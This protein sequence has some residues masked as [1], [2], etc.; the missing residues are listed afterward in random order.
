MKDREIEIRLKVEDNKPLLKFLGEKGDFK[1]EKHQKDEYFI[2]AH[3]NFIEAKP[4]KEWLRLRR[5]EDKH[6][7]NYKNWHYDDDGKS[8][9]CD[10]Y[11]VKIDNA[12]KL[13]DILKALN[14]KS[15]VVVD[16]KRKVFEFENYEIALDCVEGLGDYIEVE[17]KGEEERDIKKVAEEM[18]NFIKQTGCQIIEQDFVGYP[19][20]LLNKKYGIS[21]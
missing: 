19:Y 12:D 8:Y 3:R 7:L 9:H 17:Y 16:K 1:Y 13:A 11:E 10:E 15:L 18:K 6:L 2:P 5:E 20:L 21:K 14:F 4:I